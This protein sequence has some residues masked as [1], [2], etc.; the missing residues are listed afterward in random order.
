MT[1]RP[2]FVD[3][4]VHLWDLD[5]IRYPWLMPPFADDGP[6][7]SVEAIAATYLLDD[8]LADAPRAHRGERQS[9]NIG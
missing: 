8:Y 1:I 7:G 5:H 3:A 9:C 2:P 6:N 4:H